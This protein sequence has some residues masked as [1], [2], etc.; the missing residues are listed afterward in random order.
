MKFFKIASLLLPIMVFSQGKLGINNS[1][2]EATLDIQTPSASAA[3]T[4]LRF[5]NGDS[6]ILHIK[7]SGKLYFNYA[8]QDNTKPDIYTYVKNT[9]L[10]DFAVVNRDNP[11]SFVKHYS[12][13]DKQGILSDYGIDI[14]NR[15]GHLFLFS[16]G[17]DDGFFIGGYT[18][19]ANGLYIGENGNNGVSAKEKPTE[20]LVVGGSLVIGGGDRE[21][22]TLSLAEGGTCTKIGQIAF[23]ASFYGCTSKGWKKLDN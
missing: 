10:A 22:A 18:D 8:T 1:E 23:S 12:N 7:G 11:K 17:V 15:L 5:N 4:L 19:R 2:P 20:K 9:K 16:T 14:G 13:V 3:T 6:D 21:G